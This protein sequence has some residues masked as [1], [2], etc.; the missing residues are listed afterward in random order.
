MYRLQV[1]YNI[2]YS[3]AVTHKVIYM[4]IHFPH[5]RKLKDKRKYE[6]KVTINFI[7]FCEIELISEK[8]TIKIQ[9]R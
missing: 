6:W 7:P 8:Q 5:P 2:Q 4:L 9:G 1:P 3:S